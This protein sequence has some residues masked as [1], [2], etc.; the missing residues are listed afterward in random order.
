[1]SVHLFALTVPSYVTYCTSTRLWRFNAFSSSDKTDIKRKYCC[2]QK[3][4]YGLRSGEWNSERPAALG[5]NWASLNNSLLHGE[6][7]T[8]EMPVSAEGRVNTLIWTNQQETHMGTLHCELYFPYTILFLVF[9]WTIP[10]PPLFTKQQWQH[11]NPNAFSHRI[12]LKETLRCQQHFAVTI[13]ASEVP[14]C[15]W[16]QQL[17]LRRVCVPMWPRPSPQSSFMPFSFPLSVCFS[18]TS[19]PHEFHVQLTLCCCTPSIPAVAQN[20]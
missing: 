1:M 17:S 6:K 2:T 16:A 8:Q 7:K 20:S 5:N 4:L 19:F 18:N 13:K 12:H 14:L 15:K 10:F 9:L 3:V 11:Y